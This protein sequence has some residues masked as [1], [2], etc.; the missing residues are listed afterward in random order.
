[1]TFF[2]PW[3]WLQSNERATSMEELRKRQ[4][5]VV[6][7]ADR[8]VFEEEDE[9]WDDMQDD[10]EEEEEQEIPYQS[11]R[12]MG[13]TVHVVLNDGTTLSKTGVDREFYDEVRM[14]DDEEEVLSLFVPTFQDEP[15]SN[16][17]L[18]SEDEL[19]LVM[20]NLNILRSH[21]DFKIEGTNIY[22]KKVPLAMPASVAGSF[23]EI[24][25]R[26]DLAT[27]EADREL[28][29]DKYQA[30]TM[31]WYWAALNP[32][33]SSRKDLLAFVRNNDIRITKNGLLEMYRR[34]VSTGSKD[35]DYVNFVSNS[36]YK[37]KRWSRRLE[38]F[39][40]I[41]NQDGQWVLAN[42]TT[43]EDDRV[44]DAERL[45]R[46]YANLPKL[47]ENSFTDAHT[48]KMSIRVGEV[49]AIDEN[50]IDLNN[51]QACSAGLHV[52][53]R[54]FMFGGF[55]DTGVLALVNP[56]KV[57]AV[58]V[59]DGNKMR[60]SEMF[61]AAVV[62]LDEYTKS[63]DESDLAD[64]SQQYF[65]IGVSEL[66]IAVAN[67]SYDVMGCQGKGVALTMA[68]IQDIKNAL[69]ARVEEIA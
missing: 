48:G 15:A 3:S 67:H 32:I 62:D 43:A 63:I 59:Y 56:S 7:K 10:F 17:T 4:Q 46:A 38:D 52:G 13:D 34:V 20:R 6:P 60:V 51:L 18:Q 28:L 41:K 50:Q 47:K 49:Y 65:N 37:V 11:L 5:E 23:I 12:L 14:C 45:D 1:M 8:D 30:L 19:E 26:R 16:V 44:T 36:V 9:D 33:E 39:Y 40:V 54:S 55:G 64:Y 2:K 31:F 57:R 69:A 22:L 61:I 58:P 66:E 35:K 27:T 68:S 42:Q 24:L 21:E 29:D 25:E 53:S